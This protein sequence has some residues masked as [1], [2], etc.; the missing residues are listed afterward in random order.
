MTDT[1][2]KHLRNKEKKKSFSFSYKVIHFTDP[3]L[4]SNNAPPPGVLQVA[5]SSAAAT[6]DWLL[7]SATV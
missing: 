2:Y 6:R 1:L 5:W 4:A 7:Q 3:P